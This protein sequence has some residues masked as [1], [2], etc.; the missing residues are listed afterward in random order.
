MIRIGKSN[1][2]YPLGPPIQFKRD[3]A[4]R[5]DREHL[6]AAPRELVVLIPQARQLRAAVG[7]EKT[8]QEDEDDRPTS[9]LG[10]ADEPSGCVA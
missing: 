3:R 7:S 5:T 1:E 8:P 4:I 9:I 10:Q 2:W 6:G